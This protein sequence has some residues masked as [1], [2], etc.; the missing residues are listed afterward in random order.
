MKYYIETF[1][2]QANERD[3]ETIAGLL[4]KMG[5]QSADAIDGADVIIFN[6]CCIREK[7][8]DKVFGQIGAL[9][10]LKAKNPDLIIGICGCMVQQEKMPEKIRRQL[11][12]VD[13]IFELIIFMT[14]LN[15]WK[16]SGRK[17]QGNARSCLKRK[18]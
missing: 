18:G 10:G 3:S 7:A 15:C 6:T 5:Y 11:P 8:E 13:L 1:G 4:H 17:N 9:K 2:C 16:T 12:H 14:F